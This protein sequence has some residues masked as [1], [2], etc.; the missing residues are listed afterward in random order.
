[1]SDNGAGRGRPKVIEIELDSGVMV[2]VTPLNLWVY[3]QLQEAAAEQF[4]DPD[5]TPYEE[6]L[7]DAATPD[8]KIPAEE[9]PDY[10]EAIAAQ[11]SQRVNFILEWLLRR[12]LKFPEGEDALRER[13]SGLVNDLKD[14]RPALDLDD[15]MTFVK[16]I[17][18]SPVEFNIINA[19][20]QDR[21]PITEV[22]VR[23]A[24]RLFRPELQWHQLV[25]TYGRTAIRQED[26]RRLAS[27]KE[28]LA[29][30]GR[31]SSSRGAGGHQRSGDEPGT[32]LPDESGG[33]GSDGGV[34][35]RATN[36]A[37]DGKQI[38]GTGRKG[39]KEK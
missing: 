34:S 23:E 8:I 29:T 13:F 6:D 28:Q 22:E 14:I 18:V 11:H 38:S 21:L 37:G 25:S 3:Q 32:V 39:Q 36:P 7:P 19:I 9:N 4:P 35:Q 1:M 17:L 15:W 5:K 12:S 24:Y 33:S 16:C 27:L 2:H 26:S 30:L 10:Q 31:Q 20:V